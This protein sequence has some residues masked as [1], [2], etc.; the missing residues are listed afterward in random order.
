MG[1]ISA[2]LLPCWPRPLLYPQ[3]CALLHLHALGQALWTTELETRSLLWDPLRDPG[4]HLAA[5]GRGV[6]DPAFLVLLGPFFLPAGLLE[7]R[8]PSEHEHGQL[9]PRIPPDPPQLHL[10]TLSGIVLLGYWKKDDDWWRFIILQEWLMG[11]NNK[12]KSTP[13]QYRR[14]RGWQEEVIKIYYKNRGV[15]T[16]TYPQR[17]HR[18][19]ETQQSHIRVDEVMA[20]NLK[21][22]YICIQNSPVHF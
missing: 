21:P 18:P 20:R 14:H 4:R 19:T 16:Q 11:M 17:G 10:H 9:W 3:L 1:S 12:V 15:L 6:C 7:L 13:C 8:P 22:K 2:S 5:G